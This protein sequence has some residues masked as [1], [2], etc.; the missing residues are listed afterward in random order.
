MNITTEKVTMSGLKINPLDAT[1]KPTPISVEVNFKKYIS[2]IDTDNWVLHFSGWGEAFMNDA[3]L[4]EIERHGWPKH[5]RAGFEFPFNIIAPQSIRGYAEMQDVL[6][7][8]LVNELGAKKIII[9]GFSFGAQETIQYLMNYDR[10]RCPIEVMGFI[11]VAGKASNYG[12]IDWR[13]FACKSHDA[14][15]FLVHGRNDTAI[16][17][18]ASVKIYEELQKCTDRESKPL[19]RLKILDGVG[20]DAT[21]AYTP[22]NEV[23]NWALDRFAQTVNVPTLPIE[24]PVLNL[25][26]VDEKYVVFNTEIGKFRIA[27]EKMT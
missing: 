10:R 19:D 26:I 13:T 24:Y 3:N 25:N 20:H 2:K 18:G 17:Y 11:P 7:P 6:L 12:T 4:D 23:Y 16:G 15:A 8:Y 21:W 27:V 14:P 9:T 5:A 22:N 1:V